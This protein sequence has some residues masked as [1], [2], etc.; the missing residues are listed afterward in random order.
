MAGV[1]ATDSVP[2]R[3]A[4]NQV[5]FQGIRVVVER[6]GK[7]LFALVP[8]EDVELLE[9]IEDRMDLETV[10]RRMNE[11]SESVAKLKKDLGL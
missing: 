3:R 1:N 10:R 4:R 8:V 11:P 6:R 5:A 2:V 9:Q 7:G